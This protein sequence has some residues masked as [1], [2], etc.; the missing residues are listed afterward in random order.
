MPTDRYFRKLAGEVAAAL[1]RGERVPVDAEIAAAVPIVTWEPLAVVAASPIPT[2]VSE[3]VV[4]APATAV[5]IRKHV[6]GVDPGECCDNATDTT[7]RQLV[8]CHE[9]LATEETLAAVL[10]HLLGVASEATLSDLLNRIPTDLDPATQ[11]TLVDLLATVQTVVADGR[12]SVAGE[13]E[14]SGAVEVTNFPATQPVSAASLPLPAGAATEASVA[15][16]LEVLL[17]RLCAP[18]HLTHITTAGTRTLKAGPGVLHGVV[19]NGKAGTRATVYDGLNASGAVIA[20]I[21]A[22]GWAAL[23]YEGEF[24]TGLTVVTVGVWDLTVR[25][26]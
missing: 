9:C 12:V 20:E 3:P 24:T 16:V 18:A 2:V 15:A 23:P 4:L 13:V 8:A 7:L 25:W 19:C 21:T 5:A 1:A 22:N 11:T 6:M 10:D 26:G 17:R 14:V